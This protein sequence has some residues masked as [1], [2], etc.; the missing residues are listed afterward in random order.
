M[1]ASS[2]QQLWNAGKV[3][4]TKP[5]SQTSSW[6]TEPLSR[7]QFMDRAK[8][9]QVTRMQFATVTGIQPTTGDFTQWPM[10]RSVDAD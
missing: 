10:K 1:K 5:T 6:W 7:S 8:V 3:P 4:L 9:E 2:S